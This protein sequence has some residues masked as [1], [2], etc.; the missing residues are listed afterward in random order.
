MRCGAGLPE[1]R[2]RIGIEGTPLV[3]GIRR[4]IVNK[5]TFCSVV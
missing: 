3:L 1:C 5:A 2:G 4:V